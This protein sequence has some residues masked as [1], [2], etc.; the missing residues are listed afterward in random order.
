MLSV[1][2]FTQENLNELIHL[3][4]IH[5]SRIIPIEPFEKLLENFLVEIV[6]TSQ[7]FKGVL[8][9]FSALV[10]V[11]SSK[12]FFVV[13]LPNCIDYVCDYLVRQVQSL[14]LDHSVQIVY[15]LLNL[16]H[17]R[18]SVTIFTLILVLFMVLIFPVLFK[19]WSQALKTWK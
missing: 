2:I 14:K 12:T 17:H 6:F 8:Q 15:L 18:W 13:I 4:L 19:A 5:S 1:G 3:V 11:Q 9:K 7:V 16:I 10:H